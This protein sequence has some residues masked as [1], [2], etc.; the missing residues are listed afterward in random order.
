MNILHSNLIGNSKRDLFIIHGFLGMGDNWKTHANKISENDFRVH[1]ID[2]RNHGKSFWSD[3]FSFEIMVEDIYNY[4]KCYNIERFSLLGHSMGGNIGMLFAQ[5]YPELLEKIIIVD[6]IPKQYK[7]HHETILNGLKSIDFNKIKSRK[8]VD[9]H[10]SK[11]ISDER[12]RQFLLKNLYWVDKESLGLKLNI[13]VLFEFK[14]RLSIKL[15]K[16]VIFDNPSLFLYG[17]SSTYV[18]ESDFPML[19]SNFSNIEIIK[20]PASGHWVHADNPS[21]FI[22]KTINFLN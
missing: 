8:H 7:P 17:D 20:V 3:E 6:I 15:K 19:Y 16:G 21:F 1:L 22:D 18:D 14:D 2:L 10:L 13:E 4:A 9:A 12:I 5:K 11:Y